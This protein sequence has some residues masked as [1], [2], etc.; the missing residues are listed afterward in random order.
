MLRLSCHLAGGCEMP[1][2]GVDAAGSGGL[3]SFAVAHAR[4]CLRTRF[5]FPQEERPALFD[6][7]KDRAI[8]SLD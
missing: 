7:A 5:L 1:L 2:S 3:R 6:Q 8:C 4:L